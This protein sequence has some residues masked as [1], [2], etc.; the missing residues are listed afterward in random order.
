MGFATAG[1]GGN[2]IGY[3]DMASSFTKTT[4][5]AGAEDVP[6]LTFTITPGVRPIN[7]E[8]WCPQVTNDVASALDTIIITDGANTTVSGQGSFKFTADT[9][10]A[11]K[12]TVKAR[13]TPPAGVPITYKVR[14]NTATGGTKPTIFAAATQKAFL[15]AVEV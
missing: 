10:K 7:L 6:G 12:Y 13:V 9:A 3:A 15:Q 2:E 8:F 1:S 4:A 5:G 11:E 14:L